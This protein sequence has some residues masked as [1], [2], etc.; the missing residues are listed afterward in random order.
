MARSNATSPKPAE[1]LARGISDS[2][3]P[4]PLTPLEF[5][6][7]LRRLIDDTDDFIED[8]ISPVREKAW[9]YYNAR[10]DLA[11]PPKGRSQVVMSEVRDVVEATMPSLMRIFTSTPNVVEFL[12][13]SADK[14][15]IAK[16]ATDACNYCFWNE[17]PGWEIIHDSFK[18][19]LVA[20]TAAAKAYW[21]N[22]VIKERLTYSGLSKEAYDVLKAE[23]GVEVVSAE[24]VTDAVVTA[25]GEELETVITYDCVITREKS[26][27]RIKVEAIPPEEFVIDRRATSHRDALLI[28][29]RT[30]LR[31]TD[32]VEMQ[33]PGVTYE[34]IV[35]LAQE[36][37]TDEEL[38]AERQSRTEYI[39]EEDYEDT[40]DQTKYVPTWDINVRIDMDG[41]G[42]AEWRHVIACG[43]PVE[44][45]FNEPSDG[46]MFVAA[47]PIRVPHTNIGRSQADL[48][49]DL[50]DIA[51]HIV[52][53][54]LDNLTNVN[55]PRKEIVENQVNMTDVL[56]NRFNGV[57]RVRAPGMIRDFVTP[58]VGDKALPILEF[59]EHKQEMRTGISKQTVGLDAD[60]L[61]SMAETGVR[62]TLGAAQQK[63]ELIARTYAELY[64]APL[65]KLIQRLYMK[66]QDKPK[67]VRLRGDYVEVDPRSWTAE[68]DIQVNVGLGSGT[69]DEKIAALMGIKASQEQI[70]IRMGPQNPICSLEQYAHTLN[71][72]TELTGNVDTQNFFNPPERVKKLAPQWQDS[73]AKSKG[74]DGKAQE[75]QAKMQMEMQI[76]QQQNQ[77][78]QA[79]LKAEIE[80]EREK[81]ANKLNL[82]RE[83]A[84]INIELKREEMAAE[85]KLSAMKI[86]HG[87]AGAGDTDVRSPTQ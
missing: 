65:F 74:D 69:N 68:L 63:V 19:G 39:E 81:A 56:D 40:Q 15:E 14:V 10:T 1:S 66:H 6:H 70:L 47:S 64:M 35:A 3:A 45:L 43:E 13:R 4:E 26:E 51:T 5:K 25:S 9:R 80:L 73:Q 12:A 67:M 86:A 33:L 87:M 60:A 85:V 71:R 42:I 79:K 27:G 76:A 28:G 55:N 21:T 58:F 77:L 24:E 38:E 78:A 61:Q 37:V 7:A 62:G 44:I 22:E 18:S 52:R 30:E 16:Q 41:D 59:I 34:D 31:V 8:D 17:N 72:L 29:Q 20:R 83:L 23:E 54:T 50:Q 75:A 48:T 32:L 82:E 84:M 36:A 2:G 11:T 57:V 53:Q 46:E 49:V